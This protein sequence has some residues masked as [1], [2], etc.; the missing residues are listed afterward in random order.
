MEAEQGCAYV[1]VHGEGLGGV[2]QEA[3]PGSSRVVHGCSRMNSRA[4][5]AQHLHA[6]AM[7]N[8][9]CVR[10]RERGI[11]LVASVVSER[12]QFRCV[13]RVVTWQSNVALSA[14]TS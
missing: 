4:L 14:A 13:I 1:G 12:C 5:Q 6:V 7:S 3:L 2:R 11:P 10:E 8:E 9:M